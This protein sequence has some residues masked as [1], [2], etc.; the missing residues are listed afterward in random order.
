MRK[1]RQAPRF[2]LLVYRRFYQMWF[3]RSLMLCLLTMA[4]IVV[5]PA[6]L[7]DLVSVLI[8]V[9]LITAGLSFYAILAFFVAFVQ[10]HPKGMRIVTPFFRFVVSY[11][12]IKIVR[13]TQFKALFPPDTI[14]WSQRRLASKLYGQSCVLVELNGYP[15]SRRWLKFWLNHF[16]LPKRVTGFSFMVQ[17]WLELSNA[18]EAARTDWV[19][20]RLVR[21]QPRMVERILDDQH[22]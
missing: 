12:R 18:I 16:L 9:V 13:T 7:G 11:G 17:D 8:P 2:P 6:I 4:V 20:R 19:N 14:S 5:R 3:W 15:L 10:I 22:H 1:K 21:R